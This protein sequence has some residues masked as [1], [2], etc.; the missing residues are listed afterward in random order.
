MSHPFYTAL[1]LIL[2]TSALLACWLPALARHIAQAWRARS[3]AATAFILLAIAAAVYA[4]P[5]R[6]EKGGPTNPPPPAII[7][8]EGVIRLYH[9]D[10]S[11]RLVPLGAQI[12]KANP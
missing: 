7:Q 5:S 11:G 9:E 3:D 4:F 10:A 12:R 2:W 1:I 8:P 6:A